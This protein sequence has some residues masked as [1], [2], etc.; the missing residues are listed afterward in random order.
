MGKKVLGFFA[1]ELRR[2]ASRILI[3]LAEAEAVIGNHLTSGGLA[4]LLGKVP[5]QGNAAQ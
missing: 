4:Q 3:G 2:Q 5:P 1:D